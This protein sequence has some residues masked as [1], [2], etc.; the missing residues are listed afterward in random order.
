MISRMSQEERKQNAEK[1]LASAI[2]NLPENIV[3]EL[4]EETIHAMGDWLR[5]IGEWEYSVVMKKRFS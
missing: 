2:W 1:R 4:S 3:R 5:A